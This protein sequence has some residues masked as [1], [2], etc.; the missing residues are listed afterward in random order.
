MDWLAKEA[1]KNWLTLS[2]GLI[3]SVEWNFFLAR[4]SRRAL[5]IIWLGLVFTTRF[6]SINSTQILSLI[7]V[8][9]LKA[10][11][12]LAEWIEFSSD[13]GKWHYR[14][15]QRLFDSYSSSIRCSPLLVRWLDEWFV[16]HLWRVFGWTFWTA[17]KWRKPFNQRSKCD[18][19]R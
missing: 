9:F 2:W 17:N 18:S 6:N 19:S 14:A 10:I 3:S 12:Q 13:S 5:Q 1:L 15:N 8:F 16:H 7:N 4:F 11:Q